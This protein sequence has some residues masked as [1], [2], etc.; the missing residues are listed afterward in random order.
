MAHL[1]AQEET[2]LWP[3]KSIGVIIAEFLRQFNVV[4]ASILL[5]FDAKTY[6]W[7]REEKSLAAWGKILATGGFKVVRWREWASAVARLG[8]GA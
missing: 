3:E 6:G 7:P 1:H 2:G 5:S 4:C 8:L